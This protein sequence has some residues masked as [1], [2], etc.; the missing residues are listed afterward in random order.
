MRMRSANFDDNFHV[1]QFQMYRALSSRD[2]QTSAL[3]PPP[4][5]LSSLV[6]TA[7]LYTRGG[8]GKPDVR[9]SGIRLQFPSS[10]S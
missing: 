7:S 2:G 5:S 10:S 8:A 6:T 3:P 1:M 9:Q 4:F